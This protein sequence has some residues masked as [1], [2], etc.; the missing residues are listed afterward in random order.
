MNKAINVQNTVDTIEVQNKT[1]QYQNIIID[2]VSRIKNDAILKRIYDLAKYL[3]I[4][5]QSG[6][7]VNPI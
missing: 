1:S 4:H 7:E 2:M 3:Y 5:K 6:N